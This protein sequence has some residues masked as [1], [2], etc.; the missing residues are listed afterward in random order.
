MIAWFPRDGLSDQPGSRLNVSGSLP[1]KTGRARK[2]TLFADAMKVKGVDH[3][4]RRTLCASSDVQRR[5]AGGSRN[6]MLD[7]A[8]CA[9]RSVRCAR[10]LRQY[11]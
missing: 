1:T 8:T 4:R 7:A 9:K 6:R 5:R 2:Q 3:R 10:T 11:A